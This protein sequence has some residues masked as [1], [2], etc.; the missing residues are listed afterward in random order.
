MSNPSFNFQAFQA[1]LKKVWK[2]EGI[3]FKLL[4]EGLI[5]FTFAV[6]EDKNRVMDKGSWSFSSNLLLMKEWEAG[7]PPHCYKFPNCKF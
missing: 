6:E 3:E 1:T 2:V 7:M 5:A 4:E